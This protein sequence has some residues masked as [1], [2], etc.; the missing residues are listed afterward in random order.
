MDD[1]A[2]LVQ[3]PPPSPAQQQPA[4]GPVIPPVPILFNNPAAGPVPASSIPST[5]MPPRDIT[6]VVGSMMRPLAM[7]DPFTQDHYYHNYQEAKRNEVA[8][9]MGGMIPAE[10]LAM[11]TPLPVL[12]NKKKAI[13]KKEGKWTD[14]TQGRA[15][16]WEQNEKVLGH[17][18]K[19][20]VKAARPQIA[21]PVLKQEK[22]EGEN[23]EEKLRAEIFKSRVRIDGGY[24]AL[25]ELFELQR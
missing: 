13:E 5:M 23:D 20:N 17:V 8:R 15:K 2:P 6:Y 11:L 21:I 14:F 3:S 7:E 4:P 25:L 22:T 9:Q 18:A 1:D 12:L 24:E 10:Q 16:K 19:T